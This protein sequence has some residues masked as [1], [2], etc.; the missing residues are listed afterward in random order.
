[1][2]SVPSRTATASSSPGCSAERHA[3]PLAGRILGRV[4]PVFS[5]SRFMSD[6]DDVV[7]RQFGAQAAAYLSSAVHAQGEEFAL[8]R[9]AWPGARKRGSSTWVAA[10][11]T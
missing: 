1:M 9:D 10:P 2:R 7:Q 6:H 3:S 8:L 11:A 5:W 4:R